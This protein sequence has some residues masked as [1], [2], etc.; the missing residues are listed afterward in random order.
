MPFSTRCMRAEDWRL[1]P[2]F[3]PS[4]FKYPE[5]LG[6]EFMLWLE[7]VRKRA[8]VP[9]SVSSSWRSPAYN[10]GVGGA[11][12][13]A[14]TDVPCDAIDIRMAPRPDDPNWNYS[15]WQIKQSAIALG[16]RRIGNYANGSL[17]LDRTEET[18]PAP[19][20]WHVVDNPA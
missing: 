15:R 10:R 18:R 17:H 9:M 7:E 19:R 2:H 6:F 5:K 12:D 3:P 13:S 20:E 14:H 16:C 1:C 11:K 4:E 8:G